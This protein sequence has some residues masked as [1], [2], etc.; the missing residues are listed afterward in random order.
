MKRTLLTLLAT[1]CFIPSFA[2]LYDLVVAK[3]GSGDYTNIQDAISAIID[4]NPKG[5]QRILVKMGVYEEKVV[6]PPYKTN[7]SLIGEN[8]EN[9]VLTWHDNTERSYTLRVDGLGF[10]CEN[11]T[12]K[13]EGGTG[14][15]AA[16]DVEADRT[17]LRNCK[18][19]G[20]QSAVF[21]GNADSRQMFY[22]CHIEGADD[23][24]TGPA[25][26]WL[27]QCAIHAQGNG[28]YTAAATPAEHAVG[29]VFNKCRFT[30]APSAQKVWLGYP[31][32]DYAAVMLK[33]CELPAAVPDE[34]WSKGNN[35]NSEKTARYYEFKSRGEGAKTKERVT[36]SHQLDAANAAHLTLKRAFQRKADTWN[37]NA[38]PTS[39]QR[40]HFAF[41]DEY[42]GK[43]SAYQAGTLEPE[44]IPAQPASATEDLVIKLDAVDC[45]TLVEYISAA[46]LGRVDNPTAQD[47]IMQRFVQS[48]R[49]RNGIRGNYATRKHYFTDWIADNVKQGT[50]TDMTETF[51]GFVKKKKVINY[52]STHTDSYPQLKASPALLEEIKKV[53][54]EL[55]AK[56]ISYVPCMRI[57]KNFPKL[58]EGDIVAFMTGQ[59]GLDVQHVGFVWRP[60]P[61]APPQLLH[62]SSNNGRVIISNATIA[63]YAFELKNCIGVKIIRL[64]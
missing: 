48:L 17:V 45:T 6:V 23:I 16:V 42:R 11:M 61:D 2:Q 46:L 18:I 24:L 30:A 63:D 54:A 59:A 9:T 33:E 4:Y 29:Y 7:I 32:R 56:E 39:F 49:Y 27:E 20:A 53:E 62:A 47:S 58:Q 64:N 5:R 25:T 52:M 31:W 43:G 55:S 51:D 34:G 8:K 38:L 22:G 19:V 37:T 3:D 57:I 40:L 44:H 21:N 28:S 15:T 10:E 26:V 14:K 60:D 35:P 13:N 1:L 50:M 36:W 12:I 41:C